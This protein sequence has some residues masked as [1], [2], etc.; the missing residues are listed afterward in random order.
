MIRNKPV[1]LIGAGGGSRDL[2][3]VLDAC[4]REVVGFIVDAQYSLPGSLVN[5]LPVLGGFDWLEKHLTLVEV[6]CGLGA[7]NLRFR[8]VQRAAEIGATFCSVVHPSAILSPRVEIGLGTSIAAGC[9][10]TND[11]RIGNH[12][13]INIGCTVSHD[14]LIEDFATLSPGVHI[15]GNVRLQSGCFIGIGTSIIERKQIG[16]W[17]IVGAGSSIINDVPPNTTVV[18]V[19]GKV[20][21]TRPEGWHLI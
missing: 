21:M 8:L 4:S 12:V 3:D 18:G 16:C 20:I 14:T 7:S 10:L 11:I 13:Q 6:I 1:A 15:A 17:S 2:F 5:D 9:V 19:P